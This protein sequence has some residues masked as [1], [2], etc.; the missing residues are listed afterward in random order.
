MPRVVDKEAKKMQILQVAMKV[1]ARKGVVKTKMIDIATEAGIGKGT[2]YEYFRRK[3][4]IFSAAFE[5]FFENLSLH[6]ERSLSK[7]DDPVRKLSIIIEE[8]FNGFLADDGR[9]A[10]LIMEFWA[11][12]VRENDPVMLD[13]IDLKS[14]YAQYRNFFAGVISEGI[15]KKVFRAVNP[16]DTASMIIALLDGIGLQWIMDRSLFDPQELAR[17]MCDILLN[18]IRKS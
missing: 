7:T 2:I 10:E 3:E 16:E 15:Q 4:Q 6:I 18:G 9:Y 8:S 12:G 11:A 1:F 13:A 17:Q 5:Y 14:M